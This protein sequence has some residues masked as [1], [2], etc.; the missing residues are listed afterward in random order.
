MVCASQ[1]G[2]VAEFL[3]ALKAVHGRLVL[4][5]RF[6]VLAEMLAAHIPP[7]AT[8]LDIGCGPGTIGGLIRQQNPTATVRG[9]EVAARPACA[10][11]FDLYDGRTLPQPDN[12]VDVCMFVDVLHHTGN[13]AGLLEESCRVSRRHILI[14]DHLSESR[15]DYETLKFMDWVGNRP[16]G[17]ALPYNYLS[18]R[19]WQ[20]L[21]ASCKLALRAWSTEVPLYPFPFSLLFGRRLHFIA[22]LEKNGTNGRGRG[23]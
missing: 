22:L 11:A 10:I 3:F 13:I 1:D 8:V 15:W 14:K 6:R 2:R 18:R 23:D 17:V 16:H 19:E 5:R 12:S 21:F 9:L 7:G 20:E 4:R